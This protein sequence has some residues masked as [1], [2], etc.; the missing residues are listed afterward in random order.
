MRKLIIQIP[1]WNEEASLPI[2]L[3]E[4]PRDVEGFDSV[5]WLVID[6]GSR[7]RTADIARE[8]G[9]DHVL[10]LPRN[11]GLANAFMAGLEACLKAGADVIVNTD[12]DNQY[13]AKD[14]P[15][16]TQP[17]LDNV[18]DMVIGARPIEQIVHFSFHKK[19]LQRL[20]S[21]VVRVVS[22]VDV[23]DAPSGF[24]AIHREAAMKLTVLTNYTYT[25][26]TLIQ[27]RH[28]GI[29]VCS[30][31]IRV[32]P[33]LRPSKL[34]RSIGSYV[35][36]SMRTISQLFLIYRPFQFFGVLATLPIVVSIIL[37]IRWLYLNIYEYPV[38]GKVHIPSLIV[39]ALLMLAGIQLLLFGISAHVTATN[40]VLLEELR[41]RMRR[42]ELEAPVEEF[43]E[44][45]Y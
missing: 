29:R 37:G 26:D 21:W 24:R 30:V 12:A 41:F 2:T 9:V 28:K 25:L 36:R 10:Q 1:C 17:I 42:R 14:I 15:K 8:C 33:D 44:K 31:P 22:G 3:S 43:K 16:L 39:A 5:E 27:A 11:Q 23:K 20:G 13:Q 35:W 38:T 4:L 6:D 40:R 19:I 34:M 18:A 45:S 32:N 7:D